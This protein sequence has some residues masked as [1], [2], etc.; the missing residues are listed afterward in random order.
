MNSRSRSAAYSVANANSHEC[1]LEIYLTTWYEDVLSSSQTGTQWEPVI[2][3]NTAILM[4][5]ACSRL[6]QN[7]EVLTYAID[8]L[9]KYLRMQLSKGEPD[10][11]DIPFTAICA[12]FLCSK[13]AGGRPRLKLKAVE[14]Y[15]N[16][17]FNKR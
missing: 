12:M 16:R 7:T 15:L 2:A 4:K 8:T 3:D 5:E 13:Y 1:G 10:V 6:F 14:A 11:E 17:T 9:E